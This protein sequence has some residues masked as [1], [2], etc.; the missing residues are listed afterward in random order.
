MNLNKTLVAVLVASASINAAY[1]SNADV[2]H[3]LVL[4]HGDNKQ[5]AVNVFDNLNMRDREVVQ[6]LADLT[7][8]HGK[9]LDIVGTAKQLNH[10]AKIPTGW[11]PTETLQMLRAA[12]QRVELTAS[13][14]PVAAVAYP[15]PAAPETQAELKARFAALKAAQTSATQ[16]STV[17]PKLTEQEQADRDAAQDVK[18][19]QAQYDANKAN[20]GVQTVHNQ[21]MVLGVDVDQNADDIKDNKQHI[22]NN[23]A[24]LSGLATQVNTNTATNTAQDQAISGVAAQL[25]ADKTASDTKNADQDKQI[26]DQGVALLGKVDQSTYTH[27]KLTQ[28]VTD[29]GQTGLINQ[30]AADIKNNADAQKSMNQGLATQISNNAHAATIADQKATAAQ[31]KADKNEV[32]I[33]AVGNE[34][35]QN[36]LDIET[37]AQNIDDVKGA[38]LAAANRE[39]TASQ[40]VAAPTPKD[41]VDG[42][43]GAAGKDG[44]TTTITKVETDIATQD[45][46]KGLQLVQANQQRTA[47][48][49]VTAT[50]PV[51]KDGKDGKDGVTTTVTKVQA[52]TATQKLVQAHND[53]IRHVQDVQTAQGEYVQHMNQTVSHNSTLAASNSQR[54]D[55]VESR[56]K[57]L[58]QQQ[59]NDREEYRA[60]I[61]GAVA[62]SG[63]HYTETD[64]SVAI[65]AGDF[66]NAQG[67]ALGYRH[68]F[69]QNVAATMAA[70]ETSN[71]D[72]MFSASAAIGW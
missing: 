25:N 71:G 53:E 21:V 15:A 23:T 61:A 70:S 31:T 46:V 20:A 51:A 17:T 32:V 52:D 56:Q 37:N 35:D 11:Q 54:L 65:G 27:D 5:E 9:I 28:H 19:D 44:V 8:I 26:A 50:A 42:K 63:L 4:A 57:S 16:A 36:K 43:D 7:D 68:K 62:I 40:H 55:S 60:G 59:S 2:N 69:S 41:G 48:Q 24:A 58:E 47:S 34:A 22:D 30:N 29:A 6:G 38:S 3:F 45:V 14:A 33:A 13:P 67:Y 49:R 10:T 18:I 1:A 66:K 64:N 39:R 12:H 72:A